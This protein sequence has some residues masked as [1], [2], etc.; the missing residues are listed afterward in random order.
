MKFAVSAWGDDV[1]TS[2]PD[3]TWLFLVT[4]LLDKGWEL[5]P[6]NTPNYDIF[7]AIE[8]SRTNLKVVSR[9]NP[10]ARKFLVA[11]EPRMVHPDQYRV[12]VRR[13]YDHVWVRSSQQSVLRNETVFGSVGLPKRDEVQFQQVDDPNPHRNIGAIGIVNEN[14]SS[15]VPSSFYKFRKKLVR[16]LSNSGFEVNVAGAGWDI[17]WRENIRRDGIAL[18][19]ALSCRVVPALRMASAP[20]RENGKTL[21]IWGKVDSAIHFLSQNQFALV[22]ENEMTYVSEKLFNAVLAGCIP[23]YVGPPLAEHGISANVAIQ[24]PQSLKEFVKEFAGIRNGAFDEI[25]SS[26]SAW[27]RDEETLNT[28]CVDSIS[29]RLATSIENQYL[30]HA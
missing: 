19:Y 16:A 20:L 6:I 7:V 21:K 2:P 14:K 4:D 30:K 27:I 17:G 5:V 10:R 26:G 18:A 24:M 13:S 15:F 29:G 12:P 28:W 8:H 3:K 1:A 25:L 22:V 23:L 9:S 11:T